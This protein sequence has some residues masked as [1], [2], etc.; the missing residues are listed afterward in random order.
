MCGKTVTAIAAEEGISRQ[1]ATHE[2]AP[3][4]V[5]EILAAMVNARLTR[6]ETMFD[7]MLDVIE[8]SFGARRIVPRR[9][10][11]AEGN[12]VTELVDAGPDSRDSMQ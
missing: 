6:L 9:V 1:W 4:H 10:R 7:R 11:D 8:A 2:A 12:V 5:Q 3:E